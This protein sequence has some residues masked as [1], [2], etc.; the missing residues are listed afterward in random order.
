MNPEMPVRTILRLTAALILTSAL[1]GCSDST[2][3]TDTTDHFSGTFDLTHA[4]A[5]PVPAAVFD[6]MISD[7]TP[8]FHLRVIAT[9]G[10]ISIDGNGHYEQR[11]NH[12]VFVD[13][14]LSGHFTRA[15][16]GECTRSGNDLHCD[17]SY[18]E[19]VAFTASVAR[20]TLTI[21]QDLSG[22]G[23]VSAYRYTWSS[24]SVAAVP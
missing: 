1:I 4:D 9:G 18:L 5:Q 23:R 13:G 8:S 24:A 20:K 16:R 6:G 19:N 3:P 10:S 22:E 14:A 17:S 2:S 21:A 11:V 12:D 7:V 15:D